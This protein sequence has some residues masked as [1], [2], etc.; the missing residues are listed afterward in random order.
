[1]IF[2]FLLI[3]PLK[4]R[5]SHYCPIPPY[6]HTRVAIRPII[7]P[8]GPT[9]LHHHNCKNSAIFK[10]KNPQNENSKSL[11][12]KTLNSPKKINLSPCLR[13]ISIETPYRTPA[14]TSRTTF[15]NPSLLTA[16]SSGKKE[17]PHQIEVVLFLFSFLI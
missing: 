16:P 13:L 9:Q 6:T 2:S 15:A 8:I 3:P 10:K 7:R 12:K 17:T 4:R 5:P 1:M 11:L 14:Y